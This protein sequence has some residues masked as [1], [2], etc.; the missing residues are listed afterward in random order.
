MVP[1][2]ANLTIGGLS[3]TRG[4]PR[5]S[6]YLHSL[7]DSNRSVSEFYRAQIASLLGA[8]VVIG[9]ALGLAAQATLVF[10]LLHYAMPSLGVGLL[11]LTRSV[12]A[13]DLPGRI[14]EL[15]YHGN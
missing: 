1:S 11:E 15:F 9:V 3:L 2:L 7:M 13:F 6:T 12:A 5:L 8:Q 14:F 10:I 4:I